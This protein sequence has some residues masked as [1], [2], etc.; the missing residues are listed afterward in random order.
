MANQINR[1]LPSSGPLSPREATPSQ[2]LLGEK[3]KNQRKP[4]DVCEPVMKKTKEDKVE[5]YKLLDDMLIKKEIYEKAKK[6]YEEAKKKLW[7][8]TDDL[9]ENLWAE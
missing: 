6:R 4:D 5:A 2:V 1:K 3:R 9:N 7:E 8:L